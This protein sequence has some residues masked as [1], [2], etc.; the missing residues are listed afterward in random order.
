MNLKNPSPWDLPSRAYF[1]WGVAMARRSWPL[2]LCYGATL[3][4]L[5]MTQR[6]VKGLIFLGPQGPG[7]SKGK[8]FLYAL[9]K[10]GP[11]FGALGMGAAIGGRHIVVMALLNHVSQIFILCVTGRRQ[12]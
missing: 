10:M 8:I 11:L 12:T 7:P 2:T 1:S 4:N 3:G 9:G 5:Y 6:A